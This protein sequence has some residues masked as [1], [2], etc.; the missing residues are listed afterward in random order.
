MPSG[1]WLAAQPL[2]RTGKETSQPRP[3]RG[4]LNQ[5][6]R[7]RVR[8]YV[9]TFRQQSSRGQNE[10]T[11]TAALSP[12]PTLSVM[13]FVIDW[14]YDVLSFF[15]KRIARLRLESQLPEQRP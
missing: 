10:H 9:S 4:M 12:C 1:P 15:G 2:A 11:K 7:F 13:A 14:F 8:Y 5:F 3:E 6:Q